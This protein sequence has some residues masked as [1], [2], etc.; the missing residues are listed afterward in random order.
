MP[1]KK[2][3]KGEDPD[4]LS[5]EKIANIV[6]ETNKLFQSGGMLEREK[7]KLK[8]PMVQQEPSYWLMKWV[9]DAKN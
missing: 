9:L 3:G 5:D 6:E 7:F 1:R 4:A 2:K 8:D